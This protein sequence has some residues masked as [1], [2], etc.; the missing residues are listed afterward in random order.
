MK[1]AIKSRLNNF[2]IGMGSIIGILPDSTIQESV[3]HGFNAD[4]DQLA[5]DWKSIGNDFYASLNKISK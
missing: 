3:Q 4:R 1:K 5:A 2:I